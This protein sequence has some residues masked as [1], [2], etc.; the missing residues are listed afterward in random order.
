MIEELSESGEYKVFAL[1]A[2]NNIDLI[3]AQ[4]RKFKPEY[5]VLYEESRARNLKV[6]LN[7]TGT[8][9][10]SG[11][12]GINF[13]AS[14]ERAGYVINALMG[15]IGL[16]PTLNA[17]RAGKTL[18]IANKETL[19]AAGEAVMRAARENNARIVP[20]DS[21]HCAIL[22]CIQGERPHEIDKLILTASGGPFYRKS[23]ADLERVTVA[24]ALN[25]PTYPHMGKKITVDSATLM[26]KG[27][28]LIEAHWLFGVAPDNIDIVIH[29]E[30][31]VHS[32]VQ[33]ADKSV[34]AQL[35]LP[36][37]KMCIRYALTYKNKREKCGAEELDLTRIKNLSF[38]KPD[39][40][41]FIL[42]EIAR[43]AIKE[44]G[45]L[46]AV[47]NAANEAA[48]DLFLRGRITFLDIFSVVEKAVVQHTNTKNPSLDYIIK[49]IEETNNKI[50][51]HFI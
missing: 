28:E 13:I 45:T 10:L 43:F 35:S 30:S 46:P 5:C 23:R 22:Q 8:K 7:D 11:I 36:D 37:M 3:E 44:G 48:V 2:N 47:M 19:V 24:G 42:P 16:T 1:C 50:K 17:L 14:H 51:R 38:A 34:K 27:L 49:C 29:R 4:A 12:D 32:L 18:G 40:E 21:E 39:G 15:Q 33:F 9:V 6:K 31:I 20:V 25:H 41:T 26:N